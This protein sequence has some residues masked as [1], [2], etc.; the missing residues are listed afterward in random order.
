MVNEI[1]TER[2]GAVLWI[3]FNRPEARNAMTLAMYGR[4]HGLCGEI[5]ADA[6]LRAVVLVGAGGQ[7]FVSG[8]DIAEFEAFESGDDALRYESLMDEVFSALENLRIPTIA[9]LRGACT[10]GGAGIAAVCDLRIA[11]PS[12]RFGYPVARTLGN[13][14]SVRN[15][16][17]VVAL[18]GEAAVKQLVYSAELIDARRAYELGVVQEV[19]SDEPALEPRVDA[20]A[21]QIAA[22]AP[23]TIAATKE[24]LRRLR[25][26]G[27]TAPDRD[28]I[29]SCY[30]SDDFREGR[31]AFFE[32]RPARWTGH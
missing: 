6:E 10:G 28:L 17:R 15:Y 13:C 8:T 22:N 20:L 19:V 9:A 18:A 3:T 5:E 32:K 23:L 25:D 4:L 31:R 27:R 1:L 7:A 12:L 24:A 11:A 14:L 16:A 29:L 30:L 26:Q 2:R 21:A